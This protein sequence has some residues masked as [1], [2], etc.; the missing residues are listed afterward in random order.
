[1]LNEDPMTSVPLLFFLPEGDDFFLKYEF[2][3]GK[4]KRTK[5]GDKKE[6]KKT[7][8]LFRKKVEG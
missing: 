1:M 7:S 8:L 3:L 6:L 4:N 5:P 2:A